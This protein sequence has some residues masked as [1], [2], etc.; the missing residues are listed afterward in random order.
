[1]VRCPTRD[2]RDGKVNGVVIHGWKVAHDLASPI[3]KITVEIIAREWLETET[4]A[5]YMIF[6]TGIGSGT[7]WPEDVLFASVE[8]AQ[9]ECDK[10]NAPLAVE[11][12]A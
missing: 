10:R 3:G 8:D 5:G 9:A 1:V 4:R 2:C 12:D 6:A 11:R 7:M